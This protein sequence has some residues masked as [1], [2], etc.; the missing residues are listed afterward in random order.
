VR[1]CLGFSAPI[2][3][4]ISVPGAGTRSAKARPTPFKVS[5]K[6]SPASLTLGAS[7]T[8]GAGDSKFQLRD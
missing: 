2:F 7:A 8:L 1:P 5:A 3:G 6:V 4:A